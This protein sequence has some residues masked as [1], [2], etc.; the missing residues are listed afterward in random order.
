MKIC[1]IVL[2]YNEIDILP[3]VSKYWE[4]LGVDKVVVFD[5]GSTDGSLEYLSKLKYVEIRNFETSGQND[6]IQKAIKED[7]YLEYRKYY[8]IVIIS[9]MDEVFYFN[10]FKALERQ[11]IDE[12][13]SCMV[14]PIFS[15]CEDFKPQP[16]EGKLLHQQCHKFYKQ[17]MNHMTNFDEFSKIS[18]FNT[19][20][21]E[22]VSM[23]VGQHY[24]STYPTMKVMLGDGFC[25][26]IDKGFGIDYKFNIRQKMNKN[27]S[28]VNKMYGMCI[29]Y[30]D[31]YE[32]LKREYEDNQKKSVNINDFYNND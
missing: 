17:R 31:S 26:H 3:F 8:D 32:K 25:L 19:A 16:E 28:D 2:C 27:L 20:V 24:V 9:D 22:R 12:G 13:Y 10:D 6:I 14:T 23:S 7:A 21:T 4:R 1:Y 15:L 11:M 29:E 18:I 30:A 5:N